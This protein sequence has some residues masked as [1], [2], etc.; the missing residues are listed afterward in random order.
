M[1]F[2]ELQENVNNAD[3]NRLEIVAGTLT[4]ETNSTLKGRVAH[5]TTGY[6]AKGVDFGTVTI[7]GKNLLIIYT[8]QMTI[9]DDETYID[10]SELVIM[11]TGSVGTTLTIKEG[12]RLDISNNAIL[13]G[14]QNADLTIVLE[15]NVHNNGTVKYIA[16][17]DDCM[18][19]SNNHWTG[20]AAE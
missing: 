18:T 9:S 10:Q 11:K 8:D 7:A 14:G 16:N 6:F 17:P 2:D 19:E 13:R 12:A 4:L 20:N 1:T 3:A 5:E 15:G